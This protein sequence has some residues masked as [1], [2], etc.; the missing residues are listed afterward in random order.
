MNWFPQI[1][2][3]LIAVI[4]GMHVLMALM[5]P[6]MTAILVLLLLL[7]IARLAARSKRSDGRWRE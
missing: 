3:G 6:Y 1:I 2:I 4:V 5:A 7:V